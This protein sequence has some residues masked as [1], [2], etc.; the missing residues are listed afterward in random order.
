MKQMQA[1]PGQSGFTLIELL[2]VVAIIGILAAIAVPAYQNY[3]KRARFAD[4]VSVANGLKTAIEVCYSRTS[5]FAS[6]DEASELGLTNL[7]QSSQATG[8]FTLTP[9]SAAINAT[10]NAAAGG[11]TFILTPSA[12][13][14]SITWVQSGTCLGAGAC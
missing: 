1:R 10:G 3:T 7:P 8:A 4:I 2:I 12:T 5:N 14:N 6:C 11:Y 9:S 13:E